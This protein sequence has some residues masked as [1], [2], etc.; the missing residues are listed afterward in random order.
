MLEE[1]VYSAFF[2]LL[3]LVPLTSTSNKTLLED[4]NEFNQE[5]KTFSHSRLIKGGKAINSRPFTMTFRDRLRLLYLLTQKEPAL[6]GKTIA[7]C[8]SRSF[9]TSN[10]WNMFSTTFSFQEWHSVEEFK[11][12]ILRFIQCSPVLDS[13]SCI[14]STR[15]N[16]YESVV[17]PVKNYLKSKGVAFI[18]NAI[19][20]DIKF[21]VKENKYFV[22]SI[23]YNRLGKPQEIEVSD[24]DLAFISLGSMTSG[25][26]AGDMETA[27]KLNNPRSTWELELWHKISR[28]NKEFGKPEVF[29]S[30]TKLTGWPCFT[31]TF[32]NPI[33]FKLLENITKTTAGREGPL[34]IIDS[35]W[36]ISFALPNQPHFI[37]Q[38][39]DLYVL[40]GYGMHGSKLGDYI[41]KPMNQ[42][43]G[44]EILEE[45]LYHL[46]FTKQ[47]DEILNNSTC[48][49]CVLPYT[50]SQFMPHRLGDRPKVVPDCA[51]NFGFI[52]QFC[53]IK[54]DIVFTLEY[55]VRSAQIAVYSYLNKL[56]RVTPIYRGWVRL[57]HIFN[58]IRTALR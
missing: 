40:W 57:R 28:V 51:G 35:S 25:F 55:S 43:T 49:P 23:I 46:K 9:F 11:R 42:C 52:G 45:I 54:D 2:D 19:V 34:T 37:E 44:R 18:G 47:M 39:K 50:T 20:K 12:Y 5:V 48:V 24:R 29:Y 6:E 32:K 8:F 22:N 30:D 36:L 31:I 15:Y 38:P 4:F 26:C 1:N 14:R 10:F 58:A 13:Q 41:K 17:L 21:K 33:F 3:S 27:P 53:E 16:Q 56:N 7:D